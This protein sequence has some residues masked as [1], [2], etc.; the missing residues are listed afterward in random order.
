MDDISLRVAKVSTEVQALLVRLRWN[1]F[2]DSSPMEQGL[3][4]NTLLNSTLVEDLRMTVDQLSHFLWFYIDFAAADPAPDADYALQHQ[5]LRR[6]TE[7]LRLLHRSSCPSED[8]LAF[9]ERVTASVDQ[10]LEKQIP[11]ELQLERPA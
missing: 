7:M 3:T 11:P 1:D 4:L 6:I 5:R 9:I 8:P 10:H 2:E